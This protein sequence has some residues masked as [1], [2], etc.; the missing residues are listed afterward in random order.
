MRADRAFVLIGVT[1][2]MTLPLASQAQTAKTTASTESNSPFVWLGADKQPLPFQ[3][4]DEMLAYLR[5]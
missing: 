2:L 5:T 4:A 1:L 3:S